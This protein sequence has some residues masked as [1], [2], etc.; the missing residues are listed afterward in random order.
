MSP[1]IADVKSDQRVVL[2]AES[3]RACVCVCGGESDEKEMGAWRGNCRC[4]C[5]EWVR[6]SMCRLSNRQNHSIF[7]CRW[8]LMS[9]HRHFAIFVSPLIF[10]RL[11]HCLW[12]LWF[13][14]LSFFGLFC[15][16]CC[17]CCFGALFSS[18]A[19]VVVAIVV[20]SHTLEYETKK[21]IEPYPGIYWNYVRSHP[22]LDGNPISV[23]SL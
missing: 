22:M 6:E 3:A 21:T 15:V 12:Y 16:A 4:D 20:S 11:A 19:M 9:P 2:R 10:L 17:C 18:S 13:L 5:D 1:K 7:H 8:R 23:Q 14:S